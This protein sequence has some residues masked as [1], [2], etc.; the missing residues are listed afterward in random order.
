MRRANP[1]GIALV[2][3]ALVVLA[4]SATGQASLKPGLSDFGGSYQQIA[5]PLTD[6]KQPAQLKAGLRDFGLSYA[7]IAVPP[8][9]ASAPTSERSVEAGA[10]R[11]FDWADAAVGATATLGLLLVVGGLGVAL[12]LR[13]H[14]RDLRSA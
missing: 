8:S 12:V 3:A 7:Q 10:G 5:V 4:G 9:A 13:N 6:A 1:I 11:D 14:R 2:L